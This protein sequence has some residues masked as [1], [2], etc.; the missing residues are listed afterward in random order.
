M[1][2]YDSLGRAQCLSLYN[3]SATRA[4]SYL[5]FTERYMAGGHAG[6]TQETEIN[7]GNSQ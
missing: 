6:R 4:A 3:N 1:E 2:S 7:Q 5:L